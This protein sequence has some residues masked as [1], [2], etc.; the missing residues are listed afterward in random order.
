MENNLKI[1]TPISHLFENDNFSSQIIDLSD[2]LECRDH[3]LDKGFKKQELFHCD[4]QV[5]HK[6]LTDD[7]NYLKEI[8]SN[9]KG[10][11]FKPETIVLPTKIIKRNSTFN[12]VEK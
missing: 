4:L 10:L 1:A 3:S 5:I 8:K 7:F 6:F 11:P 2:C 12:L 9:K